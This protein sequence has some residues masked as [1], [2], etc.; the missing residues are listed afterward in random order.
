MARI[1]KE[2][3]EAHIKD[4][5]ELY[6]GCLRNG[7]V[8]PSRKSHLCTIDFMT[9]TRDRLLWCPWIQKSIAY[10]CVRPPPIAQLRDS[11]VGLFHFNMYRLDAAEQKRV[12]AYLEHVQARNADVKYY[13]QVIGYLT[14][15]KHEIFHKGYMPPKKPSVPLPTVDNSNGFYTGLPASTSKCK[16]PR[17]KL[18]VQPADRE[19]YELD[20]I[21]FQMEKL[22]KAK[23]AKMSN[24]K[25]Y[26]P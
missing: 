10:V 11:I 3:A 5:R 2:E 20:K 21:D 26:V 14:D 23:Q 15:G 1:S 8:L 24:L 22:R 25:H 4:H 13:V 18:N 7:L 19:K 12:R 16:R 17:W 9:G 6:E